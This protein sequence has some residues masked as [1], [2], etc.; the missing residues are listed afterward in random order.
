[1]NALPSLPAPRS[2]R[3][4]AFGVWAEVCAVDLPVEEARWLAALGVH[5]GAL[6]VV[7]RR[8]LFG[9]PFHVSTASGG[10]FALGAALASRVLVSPALRE[11]RSAP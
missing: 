7:L 8:A 1:M 3:S 10:A 6:L 5:P 9:G 4:H 2:L 11:A